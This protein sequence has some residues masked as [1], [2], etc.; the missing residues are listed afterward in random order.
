MQ[1]L[2]WRLVYPIRPGHRDRVE[3]ISVEL[4]GLEAGRPG[5]APPGGEQY[6][7]LARELSEL[8][9]PPCEAT[10]APHVGD[11]PDWEQ[12]ILL[13]FH[14]GEHL[15]EPLDFADYATL[16][17]GD[18]DCARCPYR[19]PYTSDDLDPCEMDATHLLSAV[20]DEAIIELALGDLEPPEMVD[21]AQRLDTLRRA[22][23]FEPV[24]GANAADFLTKASLFLRFWATLGFSITAQLD[25]APDPTAADLAEGGDPDEQDESD[26]PLRTK[27]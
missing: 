17:H 6:D 20:E 3:E 14:D 27:S 22:G 15:E 16:R 9:I 4:T 10:D 26:D 11:S 7:D 12:R 23:T 13:E 2:D 5:G 25:E 18:Y 1:R 19:T 24:E 21:L 8:T